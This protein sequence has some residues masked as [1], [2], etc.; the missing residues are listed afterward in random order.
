[1]SRI[2]FL[3]KK[4]REKGTYPVKIT[5]TDSYKR[6]VSVGNILTAAWWLTDFNG[7]VI[8]G[9][10]NTTLDITNPLVVVMYG[11]D[12][13]ITDKTKGENQRVLTLRGTYTSEFGT[14]LPFTYSVAFEIVNELVIDIDL[15]V[16]QLEYAFVRD[17]TEAYV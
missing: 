17:D 14:G 1:M 9:K 8:N 11:D 10:S 7:T 6:L 12:L 15:T 5:V 3:S 16:S 4:A 2:L 13:Q